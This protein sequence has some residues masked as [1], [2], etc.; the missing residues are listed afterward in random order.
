MNKLF[1][2]K[3]YEKRYSITKD[4]KIWSHIGKGRWLKL[5]KDILGYKIIGLYKNG[6]QRFLLVHRLLAQ[7]FIPNPENKPCI[8][9]KDCNPSNNNINN[10]KWCTQKENIQYAAK[11]GRMSYFKSD[12]AKKNMSEAFKGR[13]HSNETKRKI[14]K[15][16]KG[17]IIPE[18]TKRKIGVSHK[19]MKYTKKKQFFESFES[20][21]I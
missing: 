21:K 11:L 13:K 12:E 7:T 1:P 4:G 17:R 19:G 18:E 9:H 2:I 3:G 5:G 10:L 20:L 8:N 15:A 16:L 14:S 6:Y